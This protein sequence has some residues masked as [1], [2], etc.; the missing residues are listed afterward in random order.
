MRELFW[1]VP[2]VLALVAPTFYSVA[3]GRFEVGIFNPF[4]NFLMYAFVTVGVAGGMSVAAMILRQR[5]TLWNLP[6]AWFLAALGAGLGWLLGFSLT[7]SPG[8][9]ILAQRMIP[10]FV[11]GHALLGFVAMVA[12]VILRPRIPLQARWL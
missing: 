3:G 6:V 5:V 2:F 7:A 10:Q 9:T 12:A 1:A 8:M 11:I 4:S